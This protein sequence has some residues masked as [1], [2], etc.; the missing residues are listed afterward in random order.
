MGLSVVKALVGAT[1][2][3]IRG[4]VLDVSLKPFARAL[5]DLDPQLYAKWNPTKLKGHGCWE[6]RRSP[7]WN[8]VYDIADMGTWAII[9]LR[10]VES[11]MIHHILDCAFLNY[12]QIRKLKQMD[13]WQWGETK[14]QGAKNWLNNIDNMELQNSKDAMNRANEAKR[15]AMRHYRKEL[16]AFREA[17]LSGYN[18][19]QIA[20]VWDKA[21]SN[22]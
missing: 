10:P 13:T 20:D 21:G 2:R 6:I 5:R 12:D 16:N 7:D 18:P 14:E 11:P 8:G 1:G 15:Y 17:V 3:I 19:H 22:L 4:H 9:D